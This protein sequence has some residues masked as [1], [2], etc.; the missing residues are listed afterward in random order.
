MSTDLPEVGMCNVGKCVYN[1]SGKCCTYGINVGGPEPLCDTYYSNGK[2]G[3]I[4]EFLA[5]V[6]ACKVDNCI[7]NQSYECSASGV[8][9]VAVGNRAECATFQSRL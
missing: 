9:I 8:D 4:P 5:K 1:Y 2:K 7:H 3:G 6:G